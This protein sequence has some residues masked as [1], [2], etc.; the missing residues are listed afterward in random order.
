MPVPKLQKQN[1]P[2]I[3]TVIQE[4]VLQPPAVETSVDYRL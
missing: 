2:V 4:E 3:E 1:N